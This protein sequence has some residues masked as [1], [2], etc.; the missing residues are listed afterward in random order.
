MH[1]QRGTLQEKDRFDQRHQRLGK[2]GR[3]FPGATGLCLKIRRAAAGEKMPRVFRQRPG[4]RARC[5]FGAAA[6]RAARL[7]DWLPYA[8]G[9][10]SS[11]GS[12]IL[13]LEFSGVCRLSAVI[14]RQ[15]R[16]IT[17]EVRAGEPGIL[18][19]GRIAHQGNCHLRLTCGHVSL[20]V[21]CQIDGVDLRR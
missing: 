14:D 12:G 6:K 17:A 19:L 8:R 10:L 5:R 20:H 3:F 18:G 9:S 21:V 2:I 13:P 7:R 15:A 4:V 16:C 11:R 1:G